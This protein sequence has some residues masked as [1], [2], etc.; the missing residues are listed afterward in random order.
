M[1]KFWALSWLQKRTILAA[2]FI[3]PLCAIGLRLFG[4]QRTANR[5]VPDQ[6]EV[7]GEQSDQQLSLAL[8]L[9]R[10]VDI[11]AAFGPYRANCLKRSLVLCRFLR[12]H[13]IP[14]ELKI[15]A[16]IDD[17][18]FSAHAWVV[19]GDVVLNERP[20]IVD[21]YGSFETSSRGLS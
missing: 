11:A 10:A 2:L 16:A 9:S 8:Q 18:D 12:R 6:A 3:L 5:M 15:G 19:S 20:D 17:G 7:A 13:G 14:C 4:F 21:R 1:Q